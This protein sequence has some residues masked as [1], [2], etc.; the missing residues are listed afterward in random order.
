MDWLD[1]ESYEEYAEWF[2][3]FYG[4]EFEDYEDCMEDAYGSYDEDFGIFYW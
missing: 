4:P 3:R 2:W 1:V